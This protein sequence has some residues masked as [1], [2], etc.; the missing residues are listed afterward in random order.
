MKFKY[1]VIKKASRK[2]NA[3]VQESFL[4]SGEHQLQSAQ[5]GC[6][7]THM[8][9]GHIPQW[10]LVRN[11]SPAPSCSL[12]TPHK[13]LLPTPHLCR[14]IPDPNWAE[15]NTRIRPR[16]VKASQLSL[17]ADSAEVSLFHSI[18]QPVSS[19]FYFFP[20]PTVHSSD[21]QELSSPQQP[22][23]YT[24]GKFPTVFL[25]LPAAAAGH[26]AG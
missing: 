22:L 15:D 14:P 21:H 11:A 9:P 13:A 23:W 26:L 19:G 24:K 25:A 17:Q 8:G 12:T 4:S 6:S 18:F 20:Q 10:R 5:S 1:D 3:T 2:A 16:S 7:A